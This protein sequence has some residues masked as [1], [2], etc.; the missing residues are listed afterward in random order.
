MF[1]YILE[2][3]CAT[4]KV[5][6]VHWSFGCFNNSSRAIILYI[7][8]VIIIIRKL[9]RLI[10]IT[11]FNLFRRILSGFYSNESHCVYAFECGW[12][13]VSTLERDN[14]RDKF[15]WGRN[16]PI[17]I[18]K[19]KKHPS[20]NA[21]RSRNFSRLRLPCGNFTAKS[22][23]QAPKE[24]YISYGYGCA[25]V[26]FFFSTLEKYFKINKTGRTDTKSM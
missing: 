12:V 9:T 19:F 10:V 5:I 17:A 11:G 13:S 7:V 1:C 8:I 23:P 24:A 16:V 20:A 14:S 18:F 2:A 3:S 6:S 21:H 15:T 26:F 25:P 22:S 4:V